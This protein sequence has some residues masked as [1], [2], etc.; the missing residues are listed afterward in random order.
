[1]AIDHTHYAKV[2]LIGDSGVGKT[3]LVQ[4]LAGKDFNEIH[5]STIGVDFES[6]VTDCSNSR[7][8]I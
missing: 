1:M 5:Q 3:C 8:V 6:R 7:Y 4:R 2:I